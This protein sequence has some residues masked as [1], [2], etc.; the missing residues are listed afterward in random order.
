MTTRTVAAVDIGASSG[1]VMVATV[2]EEH[3][4]LEEVHRFRNGGV[5]VAGRLQWDVLALYDGVLEGLRLAARQVPRLD[6]VGIDT[7][8]VDYGLLD[9]DGELLSNPVHYRDARTEG[10]AAR[11]AERAGGAAA[12]YTR[13]GIQDLPFNTVNQLV[14]E[15][16]SARLAAARTL[17]L[18][19]DLLAYWLT[20]G[21][22]GGAVGAEVTNASTTQLLDARTRTWDLDLVRRLG[23][24]PVLLPPLREPGTVL[25]ELSADVL[26][27][28]GLTGPVPVVAVGSHDTAS[29]VVGTPGQGRFAYV[30]SGTWSLVGTELGAPVLTEASRRANFTNEAGVDGTVRYLRNVM[31]LWLLQESLRTWQERGEGVD[32]GALLTAAAAE[33]SG[34]SP[35][36]VDDPR[37]LPP[38]DMPARIGELCRE[39]GAPAP[40]TPPQ[41]AR[42]VV[43]AL[44]VAHR[45]AVLDLERLTGSTVDTVHVVGGGSQN[46]LLCQ[47]T[48]DAC[49][50]PVVA[51]PV[52]ATA[53]GNVLVQART[54]GVDLGDLEEVRELARSA[55]RL[56]THLPSDR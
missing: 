21:P 49:G 14:A 20:G 52:E 24:D 53:L 19:P 43:D 3:V 31:G 12:L 2:S 22:A 54:V 28:I 7:W 47:A 8:A 34:R 48:A 45:D 55:S 6:S 1:R 11:V 40:T 17:L 18:V 10:V 39:S 30:S 37:L 32:L 23:L 27:Q 50:R 29:A 38:G 15:Q 33:P 35:F 36:D 44:A 42:A 41:V 25:G 26:G 16:G 5:R 51:G 13:T 9:A 46:A 4:E 56:R